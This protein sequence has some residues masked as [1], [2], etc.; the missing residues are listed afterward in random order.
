MYFFERDDRW[1]L[2]YDMTLV[3]QWGAG[4]TRYISNCQLGRRH[5]E[6]R[7]LQPKIYM[8]KSVA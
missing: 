6:D 2:W 8:L 7:K 1:E 5:C 4:E 3:K